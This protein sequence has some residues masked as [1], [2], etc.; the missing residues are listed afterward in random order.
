VVV[1]AKRAGA[2]RVDV[3]KEERRTMGVSKVSFKVRSQIP[4]SGP[5]T[6]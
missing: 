3:L 1:R 2:W 4:I 5:M 6:S